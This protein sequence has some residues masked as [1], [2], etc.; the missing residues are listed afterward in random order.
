MDCGWRTKLLV[1]RSCALGHAW[2]QQPSLNMTM[3]MTTGKMATYFVRAAIR[4]TATLVLPTPLLVPATTTALTA[5]PVIA[6]D[7][8]V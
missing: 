3:T 8:G 6:A 1:C 5:R 7:G 2:S 4:P